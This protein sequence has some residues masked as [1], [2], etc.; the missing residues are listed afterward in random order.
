MIRGPDDGAYAVAAIVQLLERRLHHRAVL[1][2]H[3]EQ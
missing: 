2:F 1:G 3:A